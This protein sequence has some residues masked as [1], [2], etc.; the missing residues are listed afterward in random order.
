MDGAE[1]NRAALGIDV[2]VVGV[3]GLNALDAES[4]KR[5]DVPMGMMM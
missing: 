1:D 5:S 4:G 2:V 3:E